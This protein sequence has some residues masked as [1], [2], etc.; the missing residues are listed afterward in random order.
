MHTYKA[1]LTLKGYN[2]DLG[3]AMPHLKKL[4]AAF[5]LNGT[6]ALQNESIDFDLEGDKQDCE[7]FAAAIKDVYERY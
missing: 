2:E 5:R 1:K 7:G 6:I 4:A 3:A